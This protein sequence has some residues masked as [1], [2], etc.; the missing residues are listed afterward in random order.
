MNHPAGR[1]HP[2]RLGRGPSE[3]PPHTHTE[4]FLVEGLKFRLNIQDA[5]LEWEDCELELVLTS[6]QKLS[7]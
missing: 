4:F 3:P 7:M 6:C 2:G 1:N 5:F